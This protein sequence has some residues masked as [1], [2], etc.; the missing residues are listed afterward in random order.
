MRNDSEVAMMTFDLWSKRFTEKKP[1]L[2][3]HVLFSWQP[4]A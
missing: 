3:K 4:K 2:E 1:L